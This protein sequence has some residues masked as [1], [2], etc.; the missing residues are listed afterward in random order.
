MV[1]SPDQ[2]PV[3]R[4][5][6]RGGA[7]RR[8]RKTPPARR[9]KT[10]PVPERAPGG[11][12]DLHDQ[13]PDLTAESLETLRDLAGG[14][15]ESLAPRCVRDLNQEI[16]ARIAAAPLD[17]NGYGY[18]P[19]GLNVDVARRTLLVVALLYK[20]Y[21]RVQTYGIENLPPGRM[22]VIANHAGQIAID[23]AMIGAATVLE[24]DPPRTLR[25]MGEYWLPTIPFFNV[26]MA[27]VGGVVGTP[28][29]CV[30]ILEH[31]EAVIA[32]PEGVRGMNK[33]FAQRY[34]LQEFG[35]GFMR[36]A[37]QTNTP[38]VPVAVVGSEEQAPSIYNFK[39]LAHLLGMPAFPIVATPF[40]L[41]VRYHIHFGK[42]MEFRGNPNDEDEV[43]VKKVEQVKSRIHDMI[44]EGLRRRRGVFF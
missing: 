37:L 34:Q 31:G 2:D 43:I 13:Q 26:F 11:T 9:R 20:Y 40:L 25:G 44:Q 42:P 28:K 7:G 3:K 29:N 41:P 27:R 8:T 32:F 19:W 12:S 21:F 33:T 30:D 16:R 18:D 35:Y 14:I 17:L 22:L 24:A 1:E 36:L 15:F 23:A 6:R 10:G 4:S 5:P 38:I 39:W